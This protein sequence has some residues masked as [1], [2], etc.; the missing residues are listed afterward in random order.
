MSEN[1]KQLTLKGLFWNAI[2]RFG[3]QA[4]VLIVGVF[5][6]RLLFQE[7]FAVIS[8][9]A[10]F[11]VIATALIDS[12]LA[13]SL[14][15]SKSVTEIDYSTM[16]GF[17]L[18]F[19]LVVYFILYFSAPYIERFY[20]I[21][22]LALYARVLFL[23]IVVHAL[24]I[25]QNVKILRSFQFQI[26]ARINLLSV[27]ISGLA[28]IAI[29]VLG[30]GVWS[31]ILQPVLQSLIR[32]ILFWYWGGWIFDLKF[33]M[34]SLKKHLEFSVLFMFSTMLSKIM[35]PLYN[36]VIGKNYSQTMTGAYYQ[37]NKWG[38]TPNLLISSVIQGTT[39][40]TLAP[41]HYDY[42]RFLNACRKTMSTLAFVLFPVSFCAIVVAEPAFVSVLGERYLSS[43]P[44]FQL[45]TFAGLFMSLA[46]LNTNFLNIKGKSN[47]TLG[48]EIFKLSLAILLLFFT[49]DKGILIIVYGQ[50]AVRMLFYAVITV[51]SGKVYGYHFF[52]QLK[53]I[54]PSFII[55]LICGVIA[56][57]PLYYGLEVNNW[58]LFISQGFIFVVCYLA[59]NHLIK[60]QIWM[61][62]VEVVKNKIAK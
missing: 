9:L 15:R 5:T 21:E 33:R 53:D 17:N 39:L 58:I 34:E 13:T 24:G 28:I 42:P 57:L 20:G 11:S 4:V 46:D 47:Y 10:I 44:F 54:L 56:Y 16:F 59:I 36:S 55:S 43:V 27:V 29:A 38:E 31:L 45:L 26:T 2:D 35:S 12:G 8:A 19:S 14:V 40:S 62:L 1:S 22:N 30:Y 37:A 60:N 7:D 61:E 3:N 48:L 25:V 41:L 18:L 51:L 49:Y 52:I 6:A 23:Q 32:T 50:I